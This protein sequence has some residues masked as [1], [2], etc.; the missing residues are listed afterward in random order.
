MLVIKDGQVYD[1]INGI[2]GETKDIWIEGGKIVESLDHIPQGATVIDALGMIVMPGG[3]DIHAHI[4]GSKVNTGRKLCPEDH[5][6]HFRMAKGDLRSGVGFTVPT[7]F[8]TGYKYAEMGYTTV[9]EAASA[10]IV[11]RHTYEEL[12]DMPILDK[13]ILVTL[14]NNELLMDRIAMGQMDEA[15][16]LV[17]WMLKSCLLYTS[18]CV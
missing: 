17:A 15:R 14:G 8:M 4:A 1:P 2:N 12:D 5:Y 6:E 10:P 16:D 13:A 18:R 3:I 7:T 9:V 11:T